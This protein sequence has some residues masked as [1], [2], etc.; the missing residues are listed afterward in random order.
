MGGSL[1]MTF[2]MQ[3]R[4]RRAGRKEDLESTGSMAH[5]SFPRR[6]AMRDSAESQ[7]ASNGWPGL[8]R[9]MTSGA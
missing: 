5:R 8:S 2:V 6:A 4:R 9:S 1:L 3:I 7:P